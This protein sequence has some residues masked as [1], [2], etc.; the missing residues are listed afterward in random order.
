MVH[1]H[2]T[3]A[4]RIA[5]TIAELRGEGLD[6]ESILRR[7]ADP[8]GLQGYGLHPLIRRRLEVLDGP[9]D[10]IVARSDDKLVYRWF[11]ATGNDFEIALEAD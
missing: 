7:L 11:D 2:T 6:D 5:R 9:G 8:H 4:E 10:W 1:V 3:H